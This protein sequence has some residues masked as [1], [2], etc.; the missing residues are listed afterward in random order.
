MDVGVKAHPRVS[1]GLRGTRN[2]NSLL[3]RPTRIP[4]APSI[5]GRAIPTTEIISFR[6]P[7]ETRGRA[8]TQAPI[9]GFHPGYE[10]RL[11][12]KAKRNSQRYEL[13]KS[14]VARYG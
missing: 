10:S 7:G 2:F 11:P 14:R 5:F 6:S 13:A 12:L 4:A 9:P 3:V 1:P 8:L